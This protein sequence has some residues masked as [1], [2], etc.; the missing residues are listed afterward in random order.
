MADTISYIKI[1]NQTHPIDAVTVN[2]ITISQQEKNTWNSKQNALSFDSLPTENSENL[3]KSGDL[4]T[5]IVDNEEVTSAALNDLNDRLKNVEEGMVTEEYDPIFS[6]SAAASITSANISNWNSKTSNTGTLTG[7]SMNGVS[8]G[9]SGNIN[10]GTVIT[11]IT[12]NGS[13]VSVSSGVAAI[14]VSIPAA[15]TS[16]TVAGWGFTKNAAPGTLTTT[17]T[18]SLSTATNEALSGNI[19]L[20]KI[21]KT[22]T[23]SDL[24]G[25]PDLPL[26]CYYYPNNYTLYF[27][28]STADRD[29]FVADKTQTNLILFSQ[30]VS[31]YI[32][33]KDSNVKSVLVTNAG[34][35]VGV[36]YARAKKY[37]KFNAM[38]KQNTDISTFD[39]FKYFTGAANLYEAFCESSLKK[40]TL[41]KG[42]Q[43]TNASAVCAYLFYKCSLLKEI[44]FADF[45][46]LPES[47][48]GQFQIFTNC[49][50][51][52]TLHFQSI[53]Q[54][55][56]FNRT[57]YT[58]SDVPF[59]SN[60]G[61][62]KVYI[63]NDVFED[64]LLTN[65]VIPESITAIRTATFYR[66]NCITSL[67]FHQNITSIGAYAFY[68]CTGITNASLT[69][70]SS[71]TSIGASAFE[72]CTGLTGT[73]T[74]PVT[75]TSIGSKAF[76]NCKNLDYLIIEST[77]SISTNTITDA[78]KNGTV[79]VR[80]NVTATQGYQYL[81]SRHIIIDGNYTGYNTADVTVDTVESVRIGGNYY[82]TSSQLTNYNSNSKLCFVEIMGTATGGIIMNSGWVWK[83]RSGGIIHLGYNGIACTPTQVSASNDSIAKIYVGPGE[84]QAG[85]QV[86]LDM[87]LADSAWSAYSSKLDL[88]YNYTGEYKNL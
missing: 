17:A 27:F 46:R 63:K 23:Y 1:G 81:S 37:L 73:L 28:K 8:K 31:D 18:T 60:N 39:E 70:P 80:G 42:L 56:N 59:G 55:N 51:L 83:N 38:F 11:G 2:G 82:R 34:D 53:E 84:S 16:N 40:V 76:Y 35:G 26:A 6:S 79:H 24:V 7:I 54:I 47:F 45:T 29:S 61:T 4:Y 14:S 43:W 88:W 50:S 44:D 64:E 65:L 58:L 77:A 57:T 32:E 71:V 15:V 68:Q 3:V 75:V 33:F 72:G 30:E 86:I 25:K 21:A 48:N 41:P 9:T 19:S 49:S 13:N 78:A 10:L 36:T 5:V 66:F 52:T 74:I 62:H 12:F 87:Y 67:T 20:H 69:I 85:D 22:G